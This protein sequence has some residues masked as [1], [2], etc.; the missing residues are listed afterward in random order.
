MICF[1]SLKLNNINMKN[2]RKLEWYSSNYNIFRL[3][4]RVL[5]SL[6]KH[7]VTNRLPVDV[8]QSKLEICSKFYE[9]KVKTKSF[10]AFRDISIGILKLKRVSIE[11][12]EKFYKWNQFALVVKILKQIA[13]RMKI[14]D[15]ANYYELKRKRETQLKV[16]AFSSLLWNKNT[17]TEN[18]RKLYEVSNLKQQLIVSQWFFNWKEIFEKKKKENS[19]Y[20]QI[21]TNHNNLTIRQCF[22]GFRHIFRRR[23]LLKKL[24]FNKWLS[25]CRIEKR[26][27]IKHKVHNLKL[28]NFKVKQ[29]KTLMMNVFNAIRI[30]WLSTR[31]KKYFK[32]QE[33]LR[34]C[35]KEDLEEKAKL[36]R[37][38]NDLILEWKEKQMKLV[39]IE[40]TDS[41]KTQ[42]SKILEM[43]C[44]EEFKSFEIIKNEN[45]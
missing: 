1:D 9:N 20:K 16:M 24:Y 32:E 4:R 44:I 11:K 10:K 33:S 14:S 39:E 40:M 8:E 18:R 38:I 19:F 41:M 34:R 30:N 21:S 31:S 37:R 43:K 22:K 7:Y 27:I 36:K 23:V 28:N 45:K 12:A 25:I 15:Q 13:E 17:S 35:L 29:I 5:S 42:S 3:K 2:N 6:H 26:E